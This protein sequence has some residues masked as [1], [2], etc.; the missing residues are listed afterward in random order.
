M[1]RLKPRTTET[2]NHYLEVVKSH[3]K[4]I[5]NCEA[6]FDKAIVFLKPEVIFHLD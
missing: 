5:K 1:N 3:I 4:T 2:K 6:L